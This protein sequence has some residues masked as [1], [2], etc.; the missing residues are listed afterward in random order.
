MRAWLPTRNCAK[1]G[2]L[3]FGDD[4]DIGAISRNRAGFAAERALTV[5]GEKF[6]PRSPQAV[7]PWLRAGLARRVWAARQ[8][9][10]IRISK[11]RGGAL[12]AHLGGALGVFRGH[13][14]VKAAHELHVGVHITR[15]S[16]RRADAGNL[17]ADRQ[18]IA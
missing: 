18:I 16:N 10:P 11:L 1:R 7:A 4:R 12:E 14:L 5:P 2:C 15:R 3:A 9:F 8:G 6:H 17:A 13:V